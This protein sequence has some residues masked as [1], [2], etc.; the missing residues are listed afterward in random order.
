[1]PLLPF[2]ETLITAQG[3]GTALT[4]AARNSA[5]P[6]GAL[7]PLPPNFFDVPGKQIM[8]EAWGRISCVVTTPGTARFD[9]NFLDSAAANVIV[10]DS[11]AMNLNIVAKVNVNWYLKMVM[12]CRSIGTTAT[13]H[14]QGLWASE[15][16]IASPLPTVGG[17]G[18]FTLPYNTAPV[19]SPTFNSTL[20]Q[21]VDLRFTQTLATGSL[22]LHQYSLIRLN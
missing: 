3:D 2:P 5:L 11:L 8:V 9:V 18:Q 4:A 12:T 13:L 21:Q 19:V 1:M 17:S 22:T 6:T 14:W 16:V 20:G 7:Y 10:A 15:A